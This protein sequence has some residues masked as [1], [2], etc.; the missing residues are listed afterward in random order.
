[1]HTASGH[2][3]TRPM[4]N[5]SKFLFNIDFS[6]PEEPE[7]VVV[8]EPVI[9]TIPLAEHQR[10]LEQARAQAFE[11]GRVKALEDLQTQQETLL[12]A[13]VK[14][15]VQAVGQAVETIDAGLA[16]QEEDA[17]SLAFL[18]ARRLCSQL[19]G[20][21]PLA[22]T[23]AL[24]SECLGPLRKAPHLVI[25]VAEQDRDALTALVEPIVHEKGFEGRLVV[26][27]EAEISSG[28]CHIEWADGGIKR[29]LKT[30]ETEI[31]GSIRA[32]LQARNGS[33]PEQA[34]NA[35]PERDSEA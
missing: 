9:P 3:K 8:P 18:V 10:L 6:A 1:M 32:Y 27:G 13:E 23:I 5:P 28:D 31:D 29:D 26:L 19:I 4:T 30:L 14:A 16:A 15:L 35:A 33:G 7:E 21:Q 25:R 12:T 24:V 2:T 11:E 17:V 22:E 34:A 20:R